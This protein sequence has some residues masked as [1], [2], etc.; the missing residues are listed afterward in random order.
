M[1]YL[2]GFVLAVPT[3][4]RDAYIAYARA[5]AAIFRDYGATRLVE[6]WGDDVPPGKVTDFPRAVQAQA[7]ETVVFAWIEWPSREVRDAAH[8]RME[9]D[10]RV[11]ALGE[12]PFDGKRMI[13]AG[14]APVVDE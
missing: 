5:G 14:F 1:A 6:A 8:K 10:P 4:S 12:M 11:K 13:Y 7:D 2:D 9:D 3:A